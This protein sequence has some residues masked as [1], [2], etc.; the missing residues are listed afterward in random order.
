[1]REILVMS[2]IN[3]QSIISIH[4]Y[5]KCCTHNLFIHTGAKF[6]RGTASGSTKFSSKQ[7]R[8]QKWSHPFT[9]TPPPPEKKMAW[10]TLD[11]RNDAS[12]RLK[13]LL[14]CECI[15]HIATSAIQF[16]NYILV[17][18]LFSLCKPSRYMAWITA[19]CKNSGNIW[20]NFRNK[21]VSCEDE[22]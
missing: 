18:H 5:T 11:G 10:L 15:F 7:M 19:L 6:P 12:A 13:Y 17:L 4:K 3:H 14:T 21:H 16:Y 22:N 2:F 9:H 1:M 20:V 8:T